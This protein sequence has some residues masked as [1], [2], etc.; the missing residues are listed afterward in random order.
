MS[1]EVAMAKP[2]E[3]EIQENENEMRAMDFLKFIRDEM[4][5]MPFSITGKGLPSN[6]ELRDR[7]LSDK[8]VLCNGEILTRESIV[9]FPIE[10]LVFFPNNDNRRCTQR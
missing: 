4:F 5:S 8:I 3:E 10:Q 7:W 1:I 9:K 2:I 6:K